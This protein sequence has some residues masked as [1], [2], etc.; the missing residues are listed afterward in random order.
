[1]NIGLMFR[2]L[3]Q[4][5]QSQSQKQVIN[6]HMLHLV[7]IIRYIYSHTRYIYYVLYAFFC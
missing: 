5:A 2:L 6:L 7:C 4:S 3:D 1:M